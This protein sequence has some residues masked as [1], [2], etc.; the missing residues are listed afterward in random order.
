MASTKTSIIVILI[1]FVFGIIIGVTAAGLFCNLNQEEKTIEQK[2][3]NEEVM[4]TLLFVWRDN[5]HP[6]TEEN[7]LRELIAQDIDYPEIVLAQ[8]IIETGGFTSQSCTKDNNLFGLRKLDLSYWKFSHWTE[9]VRF[10]KEKIQKYKEKP[11]DYYVFLEKLP[12]AESQTYIQT[13]R[14][15]AERIKKQHKSILNPTDNGK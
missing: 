13:I 9:S 8:A 2:I 14:P 11:K 4:D 1:S 10:Y 7:I 15:V 12:Y 5:H 6:F 3:E